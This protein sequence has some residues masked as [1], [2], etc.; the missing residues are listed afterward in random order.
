MLAGTYC[1]CG[2]LRLDR[3]FRFS[4]SQARSLR[5][6]VRR[7]EGVNGRTG[8]GLSILKPTTT[9]PISLDLGNRSLSPS[10]GKNVHYA[11]DRAKLES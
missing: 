1:H 5:H 8:G 11:G 10:G 9:A 7:R 6:A 4:L 2:A 3:T